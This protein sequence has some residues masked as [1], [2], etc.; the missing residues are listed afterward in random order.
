ME[1]ALDDL[2]A[3]EKKI[4]A[5]NNPLVIKSIESKL[6]DNM[7][8]DWLTL[9]VN[10]GNKVTPDNYFTSLLAF[11]KTQEEILEKLEQ[12]GVSERPEKKPTYMEKF[13]STRFTKKTRCVVCGDEKHH[14]KLFFCKRFKELKP[15][16]KLKAVEKL[17]ACKR[18]LICHEEE[19]ECTDTY[20]CR[21]RDCKSSRGH[22]FFLR[23]KGEPGKG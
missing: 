20:L 18:C 17:G 14:E 11:L 8:R 19:E 10:P 3:L 13:A 22:H 21:N 23:P 2:R 16:N 6:P 9:M 5:I 7:K 12:L 1:K 15:V 4:G